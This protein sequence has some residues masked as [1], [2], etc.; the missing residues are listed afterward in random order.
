MKGSVK[1]K[2]NCKHLSH[3]FFAFLLTAMMVSSI[4]TTAWA[5]GSEEGNVETKVSNIANALAE[6]E[7]ESTKETSSTEENVTIEE[8]IPSE[9]PAEVQAEPEVEVDVNALADGPMEREAHIHTYRLASDSYEAT[10]TT[11]GYRHYRC[12]TCHNEY[13]YNT[14][15]MVYTVNPKTGEAISF[16]HTINPYLPNYEFMPDNEL[17]VFWSKE[18]REWRV[19]A[20]GSHDT[21]VSG[22]CGPNIVC[23]SAPVY[24]MSDWRYEGILRDTGRFFACDFNYD[25]QTDQCILYAFPFFGNPE[26]NG[27]HL[28][29]NGHSVPDAYF[30]TPLT[31]GG[32]EGLDGR[33]LFDPAIYIHEDGTILTTYDNSD[34]G[35]KHAQLAK[36][37]ADDRTTVEWT[38]DIQMADGELN[39][40]GYNPKHYEGSTI[41][42]VEV[43]GHSFWVIQY[44][45]QSNVGGDSEK[46]VDGENRWWPLVYVY[47]DPDLSIDELKDYTDWHWGGVIGDNG[48][49]YRMDLETGEV[50]DHD[51]PVT[52]WGNNHGGLAY[53]NGQWYVSNHRHT[54]TG[55]GRQG[56]IE[57]VDLS[58]KD[59]KLVITTPEYT[60]SMG[61]SIDA[62]HTWPAYIACH[63]WPTVF[64]ES[65]IEKTLYIDT[66]LRGAPDNY[67]NMIYDN[68]EY[69]LHR[70]P[71]VGITDGAE[72]G[73]K[74]LNFGEKSDKVSLTILV[75]REENYVDG[76]MNIYID[77]PSEEKGGTLIGSIDI[78]AEDITK[79]EVTAT[80]SDSVEWKSLNATMDKE[81]S[82]VHGVYFLFKSEEE[83]IICK[84]DEFT[85]AKL[86]SGETEDPG[87]GT[88]PG[89]GTNPGEGTDP[90]TGTNPGTNPGIDS[91]TKVPDKG[92]GHDTNKKLNTS[93]VSNY[94]TPKTG[95]N[96][97]I[98]IFILMAILGLGGCVGIMIYRRKKL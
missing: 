20:V 85:F 70:S 58:F 86:S 34:G 40:N 12:T 67:W 91:G 6:E 51:D 18:D 31:E 9:E 79:A 4:G 83:G 36:V 45:Y 53:I 95:D 66:P 15:P 97:S 78:S 27:T 29:V 38:V 2:K 98:G 35:T 56:Y 11:G 96:V 64:S 46:D 48:G 87:E 75:S 63:L 76:V 60:S 59:G 92:L 16:D 80:S 19:Y 47:S 54:S 1:L 17:H 93:N 81:I 68:P 23:W 94:S 41:D 65:N 73:F 71:V 69:A 7:L 21:S 37:N 44:S 74:Y 5:A 32:V 43:D 72:V 62:Y 10:D 55:A 25:L 90:G 30:D 26:I 88:D 89:T 39:T 14:D 77:A 3:K 24:D 33:N 22:W 13:A 49:F 28:W 52:C 82:G 61:E 84:L 50:V 42:R 57:K 8:T